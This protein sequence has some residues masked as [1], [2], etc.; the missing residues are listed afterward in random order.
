MAAIGR[1]AEPG[2]SFGRGDYLARSSWRKKNG[3]RKI[4]NLASTL[5]GTLVLAG[6]GLG[7]RSPLGAQERPGSRP[8]ATAVKLSETETRGEGLFLQRCS[9]CHLARKLKSSTP[10]ALAP[11]LEGVFKG[12]STDDVTQLRGFILRGTPNMPGFQYG[13]TPKEL[14]DLVAY[15]KTL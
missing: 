5:L 2:T 9:L 10:P 4:T 12:A 6:F 8:A 1:S 11:S 13:L 14:D 7:P 3:M 15:L